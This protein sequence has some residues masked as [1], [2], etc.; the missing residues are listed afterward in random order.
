M[1]LIVAD[2][3]NA[4]VAFADKRADRDTALTKSITE[5]FRAGGNGAR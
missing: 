1:L 5:A 4:R 3:T 2:C